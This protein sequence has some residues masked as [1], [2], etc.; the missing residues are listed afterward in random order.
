MVYT[1]L[2]AF[3]G[4]YEGRKKSTP[5]ESIESWGGV[6]PIYTM[7]ADKLLFSVM[8]SLSQAIMSAH[9]AVF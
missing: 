8:A 9:K 6:P 7:S 5:L 1:S 4:V 2:Y 3:P